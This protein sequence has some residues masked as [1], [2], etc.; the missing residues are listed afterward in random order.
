MKIKGCTT[1][2]SEVEVSDDA[3]L[4]AAKQLPPSKKIELIKHIVINGLLE[5]GGLPSDS[6]IK[7]LSYYTFDFNDRHTN[8]DIYRKVRPLTMEENIVYFS[9]GHIVKFLE[10]N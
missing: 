7:D 3:V 6:Y 5:S 9:L 10:R 2:V 4:E 1:T 8:D